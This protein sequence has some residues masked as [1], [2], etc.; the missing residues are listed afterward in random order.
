MVVQNK[1]EQGND[2]VVISSRLKA[3]EVRESSSRLN[4]L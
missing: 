3:I 4:A 2:R 1:R